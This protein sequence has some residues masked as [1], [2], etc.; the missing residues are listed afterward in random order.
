M[1]TLVAISTYTSHPLIFFYRLDTPFSLA[2]NPSHSH[3]FSLTM[4]NLSYMLGRKQ[5]FLYSKRR[6]MIKPKSASPLNQ[7][8]KSIKK[9]AKSQTR[10]KKKKKRQEN[11]EP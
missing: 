6:L 1:T 3:T 11:K 4:D 7:I 9:A 2:V 10:Q 8:P 5:P